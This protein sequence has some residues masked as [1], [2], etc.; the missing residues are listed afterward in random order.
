MCAGQSVPQSPTAW[1]ANLWTW[2]PWRR[3][4]ARAASANESKIEKAWC[5]QLPAGSSRRWS[6]YES[7]LQS[8]VPSGSMKSMCGF[9]SPGRMCDTGVEPSI[10]LPRH[11]EGP[12][13][14][15]LPRRCEQQEEERR[16]HEWGRRRAHCHPLRRQRGWPRRG[17]RVPRAQRLRRCEGSGCAL[18]AHQL[19]TRYALRSTQT[20]RAAC[21]RKHTP[22][23]FLW[24]PLGR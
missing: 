13:P 16:R 4:L 17:P 22:V 23:C 3:G 6:Q 5:R 19:S 11:R 20:Q 21:A 7:N 9:V 10:T 1:P 24:T 14:Q 8:R 15:Q 18:A 2:S 12:A